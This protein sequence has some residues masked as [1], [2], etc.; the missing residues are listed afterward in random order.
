MLFLSWPVAPASLAG[1]IPAPLS[2]D[3]FEGQAWITLIPFRMER[4]RPRGLPPVPPFSRFDE[5][6]CLTYVVY[7]EEPG[8]WFFRI[9]AGTLMGSVVGRKLFGLPYHDSAVSLHREGEDRVFRS[10]GRVDDGD[11]R[12]ELR[13]RYRPRGPAYEA[14]PGTLARF[15]VERF[16]MF[17][18]SGSGALLRGSE[19][20]APR[21][22]QECDVTVSRNTLPQAAGIPGPTGEPTAW[23]CDRSEIRTWIP[24]RVRQGGAG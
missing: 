1:R 2:L 8:I 18:S 20:R 16:V 6:D 24:E 22:I 11:E 13:L 12:P 15:I 14:A 23:Y 9:D 3:T 7:G 10:E 5:V 17:S 19:A 4:L 21:L